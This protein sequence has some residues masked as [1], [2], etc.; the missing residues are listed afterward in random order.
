MNGQ[1]ETKE[2]ETRWRHQIR[3]ALHVP[4]EAPNL[5]PTTHSICHPTKGVR[6]ERV[7]YGTQFGM[8]IPAILY[9][10]DPM[11]KEK[12]PGLIIVNGHGG[13]K[14][15]WYAMYSGMLYAKGGAAVLTYDPTGE[16][17]RNANRE[18]E[19]REHDHIE[20]PKQMGPWLAGL[21]ITDVM[22]AVQYLSNRPETDAH[23][24]SAMGYSLGSF[25]VGLTGAIDTQIHCCVLAG[26]GNFD[27]PGE[28]WDRS[29]PMC[30][31][32]PYQSLQTMGDRGAIL[33]TLH[34]NRGPTL[35]Y[36]GLEDSVVNIPTHG[37][38]FFEH[39]RERTLKL[40]GDEI[41]VFDIGFLEGASHRPHF[42]TKPV[43]L[44]LESHQGFPNWSQEEIHKMPETQIGAWSKKY[45]VETDPAYATE[46]REGGT[47][48]L[49]N[50]VPGIN[51]SLLHVLTNNEWEKQKHT[52]VHEKWR[53]HIRAKISEG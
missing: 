16:G 40:K 7:S 4:E 35:I 2:R 50:D 11:P 8:R 36:N 24:I 21:M 15:A 29:K 14:Y 10:P 30:Q 27:G 51:R 13:D 46:I 12:I 37:P 53:E 19:T 31:G 41:N 52:L 17:E 18:S 44:W 6:V 47:M 43:A 22:Q 20:D 28:Y 9:L 34:A 26:G 3:T 49:R 25:V 39:L 42:V 38:S 1:P 32:A 48:A 23:R 45:A 33:Y 5:K